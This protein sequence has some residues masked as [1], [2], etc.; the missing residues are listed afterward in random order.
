MWGGPVRH[1]S[2]R[3]P[4]HQNGLQLL[5]FS[6]CDTAMP[7]TTCLPSTSSPV[8]GRFAAETRPGPAGLGGGE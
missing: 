6:R 4:I 1:S 7:A 5:P 8:R 3:M 2:P